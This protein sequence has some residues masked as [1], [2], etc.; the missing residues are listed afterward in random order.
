MGKLTPDVPLL[1]YSCTRSSLTS[2]SN[3]VAIKHYTVWC[4]R[5]SG[6]GGK[7]LH[8]PQGQGKRRASSPRTGYNL[9]HRTVTTRA[10]AHR[11]RLQSVLELL[12]V[13]T[14]L[15]IEAMRCT[16][17]TQPRTLEMEPRTSSPGVIYRSHFYWIASF[18]PRRHLCA[19]RCRDSSRGKCS[20]SLTHNCRSKVT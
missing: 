4:I 14:R 13:V 5:L 9:L 18:T 19:M 17:Y 6:L 15:S 3:S 2:H 1:H 12:F 11:E 20:S 10:H 7:K 8:S 16:P